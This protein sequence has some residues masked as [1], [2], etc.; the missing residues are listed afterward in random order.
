MPSQEVTFGN[1]QDEADAPETSFE[2][3]ASASSNHT[4]SIFLHLLQLGGHAKSCV[5]SLITMLPTNKQSLMELAEMITF[6][7]E[8]QFDC[9]NPKVADAMVILSM[10]TVV[11]GS[12]LV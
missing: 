12:I 11:D 1:S 3:L 8:L 7:N 6:M 4:K 10:Q 5:S 9:A 2:E